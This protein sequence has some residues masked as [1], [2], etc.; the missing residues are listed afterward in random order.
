MGWDAEKVL[1]GY[2]VGA[3]I[4]SATASQKRHWT[5]RAERLNKAFPCKS[6]GGTS[7]V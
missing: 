1:Q 7:N 5:R 3:S 4:P 6:P 2:T